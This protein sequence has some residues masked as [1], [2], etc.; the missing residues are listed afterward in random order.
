MLA[1]RKDSHTARET[2]S[3]FFWNMEKLVSEVTD[4]AMIAF[5]SF[6]KVPGQSRYSYCCKEGFKNYFYI[7]RVWPLYSISFSL[8]HFK[9]F[10]I[11]WGFFPSP[12]VVPQNLHHIPKQLTPLLLHILSRTC[13]NIPVVQFGGLLPWPFEHKLQP[14]Q[15]T[16]SPLLYIH[17][18]CLQS[19][20]SA[21]CK[22]HFCSGICP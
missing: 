22:T 8:K 20:T 17:L 6:L 9:T 4:K 21:A 12:L 16:L 10:E 2:S 3:S 14:H 18:L 19:C 11:L 13:L 5:F 15:E 1:L 7:Y